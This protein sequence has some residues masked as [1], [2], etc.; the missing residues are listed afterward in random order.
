MFHS[1]YVGRYAI[2]A[3]LAF[4]LT[5]C[6]SAEEKV[7]S[8]VT[9]PDQPAAPSESE[10]KDQP[11]PTEKP[12]PAPTPVVKT[13]APAPPPVTKTPPPTSQPVAKTPAAASLRGDAAAGASLYQTYCSSCHG[14]GITLGPLGK[15]LQPPPPMHGDRAFMSTLSDEQLYKAVKEGGAAVGKSPLM[16]PFGELIP[17][18][19][20]KDLIA[21]MRKISGT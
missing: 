6:G 13:P 3:L 1:I 20:I 17:D 19:G 11:V 5:G 14:D 10:P 7:P 16:A 15:A 21:H 8:Q 12:E 9:V 4:G 18:Q 2:V